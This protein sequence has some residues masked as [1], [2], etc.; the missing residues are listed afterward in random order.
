MFPN[1]ENVLIIFFKLLSY[2]S[3]QANESDIIY[4]PGDDSSVQHKN[5]IQNPQ[6][7][8]KKGGGLEKNKFIF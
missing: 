5:I 7:P 4:L 8:Q 6:K 1:L 2:F 3:I